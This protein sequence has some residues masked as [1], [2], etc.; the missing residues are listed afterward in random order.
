MCGD[1]LNYTGFPTHLGLHK[2]VWVIMIHLLHVI[3]VFP[4]CQMQL[5]SEMK[6]EISV[7]LPQETDCWIF[8]DLIGTK[9]YPPCTIEIVAYAVCHFSLQVPLLSEAVRDNH[10]TA[11]TCYCRARRYNNASPQNIS[12]RVRSGHIFTWILWRYPE[13]AHIML[14]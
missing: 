5:Q 8:S 14:S 2:V 4:P 13:Y 12:S 7:I 3:I 6:N 9:S 11:R 10:S 1:T